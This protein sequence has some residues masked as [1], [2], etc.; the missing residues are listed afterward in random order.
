MKYVVYGLGISGI[1]I[2]KF[3]AQKNFEVIATDD[4][5]QNLL[6]AKSL[7]QN[8]NI[9]FLQ[10]DEIEFD[11]ETI[12]SLTPGIALHF[13]KPHKILEAITKNK[14]QLACDME[15]FYRLN[16]KN[17]FI[18]ITGTNGKST[19]TALTGFIFKEL[20]IASE[21]G[22]NIGVP[23][24]DLP[25]NQQNFSYIFEASSYQLDLLSD[26]H[27]KIAALLN[28]TPDHIDHHGSMQNYIAAKKRIFRNQTKSDFALIDVDNENSRQVYNELSNDKN[29]QANLIPIS[30]TKIYENGVALFD[31]ILTN[32][33]DGVNYKLNL[34]SPYLHGQHNDQNMA[35]AFAISYCHA[36]QNNLKFDQYKIIDAIK[37]FKGLPHRMQ[38]LGEIA[39]I[40]FINDSKATNAESTVHA[41]KAYDN[42]FWILGGRAKEGGISSLEPYFKK[43]IKAYLIG[44]ATEEFAT[45]LE[46]NSVNFVKCGDLKNAIAQSF[47]DAKIYSAKEKNI[48]LSPAC[49]SLDQWKNFEERG[50]FFYKT[51]NEIQNS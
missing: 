45:V 25:Q 9:K 14:A 20:K 6:K 27:F 10:F 1:S 32:K 3:L 36:L 2:A 42:I 28:I 23:C 8:Y 48:L 47:L 26:T 29:F 24:F 33:I 37:K 41:L 40:K 7:Y 13:P 43:I 4:N 51:F 39:G 44:E 17:N 12:I 34:Q 18:A 19:T 30:T 50:D 16:Q 15:I 5:E 35:F 31:G 22:G 46:K 21:I 49:A 11:R 38:L